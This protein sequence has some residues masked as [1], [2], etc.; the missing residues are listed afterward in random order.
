MAD[1]HFLKS[2]ALNEELGRKEGL[3]NQYGNLG[4]VYE[5]R[6]DLEKACR[7]WDKSRRLFEELGAKDR[8][9]KVQKSMEEA[10]CDQEEDGEG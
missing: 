8:A 2:L 3:A 7:A 4:N 10:G 5:A 1:E 9:E 6:G